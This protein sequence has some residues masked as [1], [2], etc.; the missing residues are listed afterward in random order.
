[1]QKKIALTGPESSGK[2]T[3]ARQLATY[4]DAPV[5]PEYARL[6]LSLLGRPYVEADLTADSGRAVALGGGFVGH[7]F[8][9]VNL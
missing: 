4:F 8:T 9:L 6:F 7:G 5:V 1:M 2:S 3:L